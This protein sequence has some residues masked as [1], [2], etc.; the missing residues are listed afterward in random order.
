MAG[1]VVPDLVGLF[2][3]AYG[4]Q[5]RASLARLAISILNRRRTRQRCD[6]QHNVGEKKVPDG[7]DDESAPILT[8]PSPPTP[9]PSNSRESCSEEAK[10][11]LF[12]YI[13]GD[14]NRWRL[15]SAFRYITPEQAELRAT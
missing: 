1:A 9:K 5:G 6:G 13:E 11:D 3:P 12:A 4:H 2:R 7:F 10:R 8:T 15:H 14:Y